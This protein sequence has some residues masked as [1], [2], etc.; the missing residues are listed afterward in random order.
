[1]DCDCH[2]C[3]ARRGDRVYDYEVYISN[4]AY[5]NIE[6]GYFRP[7]RPLFVLGI[8]QA[9]RRFLQRIIRNIQGK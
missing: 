6:S 7:R 4:K 1:M 3:A 9:G 2:I 8:R 5:R